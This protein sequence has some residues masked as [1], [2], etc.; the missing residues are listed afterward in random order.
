MHCL[1]VMY[2]EPADKARFRS[3]YE[4]SHMPLAKRLPGMKSFSVIYPDVLG[5]APA[6]FCIFQAR[7]DSAEAMIA[8]LQSEV[9]Q[10]VATDVPNYSPGGAT[11]CHFPEQ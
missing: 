10:K 3:Y 9:G 4:Q 1:M 6:P 8:A 2:P 5:P 11:L 7:F